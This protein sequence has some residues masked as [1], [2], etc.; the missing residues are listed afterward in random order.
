MKRPSITKNYSFLIRLVFSTL[1]ILCVPFLISGWYLVD[2]AH[3]QLTEQEN[4]R[5][6][7]ATH[8]LSTYVHSQCYQ[9][10]SVAARIS[11]EKKLTIEHLRSDPYNEV[12]AIKQL[13][14]YNDLVP[15]SSDCFIYFRDTDFVIGS[16]G[17]YNLNIFL[18]EWVNHVN[19]E[20][21]NARFTDCLNGFSVNYLST[22][23]AVDYRYAKLYMFIPI[24]I[25]K[26]ND[27]IVFFL[28]NQTSL[29]DSFLGEMNSGNYELYI[30]SDDGS[31]LAAN[32][33]SLSPL[34]G[35]DILSDFLNDPHQSLSSLD[36]NDT[37]LTLYKIND[38]RLHM[39][40][41]SIPVGE[42]INSEVASFYQLMRVTIIIFAVLMIFLLVA[43]I[44][45]NYKPVFNITKKIR[46][47]DAP[48]S[49]DSEFEVIESALEKKV[50]ENNAMLDRLAEQHLQ[51]INYT[52]KSIL[53]GKES[54]DEELALC[55]LDPSHTG[56]CVMTALN[57][58]CGPLTRETLEQSVNH[59]CEANLC[60]IDLFENILVFLLSFSSNNVS[61]R[62]AAAECIYNDLQKMHSSVPIILGVGTFETSRTRICNSFINARIASEHGVHTGIL[63]FEEIVISENKPDS[64]PAESTLRLYQF[65]KQGDYVSSMK[66]YDIIF[67]YISNIRSQ[68][69]EHYM[70]YD[71]IQSFLQNLTVL[72]IP[73]DEEEKKQLLMFKDYTSLREQAS[74]LIRRA[75]NELYER[76]LN[77]NRSKFGKIVTYIDENVANP[78]LGLPMIASH[79]GIS[80]SSLS[81]GFNETMGRGLRDYIVEKRIENAKA[82]ILKGGLSV[83]EVAVEV[84]FRDVSYFIKLFKNATGCTPSK[85]Q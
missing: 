44:Y 56:Y 23:D 75:C 36:A 40:F 37:E 81:S 25:S 22:F 76:R 57:L 73:I 14:Y 6:L 10:T 1:L 60:I 55:G 27:A 83:K 45:I 21:F 35:T 33:T 82:L 17:K 51:L 74:R 48:D 78:D 46:S 63:Y 7:Q 4:R 84:G 80:M 41:V 43:F 58:E 11:Y 64:Y 79:F 70:C 19:D 3:N 31:L 28:V 42:A 15:L 61:Q 54:T 8:Q 65:I 9:M 32:N 30:F 59:L 5:R 29:D 12:V 85:F 53:D 47:Y 77:F 62:T 66:E 69:F 49:Q 38:P 71:V 24:S 39:T 16:D 20:Q 2:K 18:S 50:S 34:I 13:E 67:N 72:S 68:I 52:T 26:P